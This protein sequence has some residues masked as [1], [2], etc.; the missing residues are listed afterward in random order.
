MRKVFFSIVYIYF[1]RMHLRK[2]RNIPDHHI[3]WSASSLY[4]PLRSFIIYL[5]VSQFS[6]HVQNSY[7]KLYVLTDC[8]CLWI[9]K[10]THRGKANRFFCCCNFYHSTRTSSMKGS[11]PKNFVTKQARNATV[12]W[13]F[14]RSS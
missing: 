10:V 5:R 12:M 11:V 14:S 8:H 13:S 9:R 4:I 6:Q 3:F 1:Y 2:E 7:T